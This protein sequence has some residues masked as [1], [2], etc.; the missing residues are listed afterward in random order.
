MGR[1]ARRLAWHGAPVRRGVGLAAWAERLG[2]GVH[3]ALFVEDRGDGGGVS[4]YTR[5][6]ISAGTAVVVVPSTALFSSRN[7]QWHSLPHAFPLVSSGILDA[8][9]GDS[10]ETIRAVP[11]RVDCACDAWKFGGGEVVSHVLACTDWRQWAEL[12]WRLALEFCVNGSRWWGWIGQLPAPAALAD[13]FAGDTARAALSASPALHPYWRRCV[14]AVDQESDAAYRWIAMSKPHLALLPPPKA[15][16]Y[17]VRLMLRRAEWLP[18]SGDDALSPSSASPSSSASVSQL[19]LGIAPIIDAARFRHSAAPQIATGMSGV[20]EASVDVEP[21]FQQLP[22]WYRGALSSPFDV[23]SASYTDN[24][25][26]DDHSGARESSR[27]DALAASIAGGGEDRRDL[28]LRKGVA[29]FYL[30]LVLEAD[31]LPSARVE[32]F[33]TATPPAANNIEASLLA[34]LRY[35]RPSASR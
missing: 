31:A 12:A 28:Q 24:D 32:R 35:G 34:F 23:A 18:S 22:D 17:A 10:N 15:F 11:P 26:A 4:L 5:S 7:A 16:Q 13:S 27:R 29:N 25:S 21:E 33:T 30:T 19:A 8:N 9:G 1:A 2:V 20:V 14:R 3:P 6:G